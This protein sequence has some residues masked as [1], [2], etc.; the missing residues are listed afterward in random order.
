MPPSQGRHPFY[1]NLKSGPLPDAC[2]NCKELRPQ[3][4]CVQVILV[5]EDCMAS[6]QVKEGDIITYAA[7]NDQLPP[8]VKRVSFGYNYGLK[9]VLERAWRKAQS[10]VLPSG[11]TR[12][13][14]H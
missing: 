7:E 8:K 4:Q 9:L 13:T 3:D 12:T 11:V 1:P 5:D 6:E 14:N 10:H 2:P